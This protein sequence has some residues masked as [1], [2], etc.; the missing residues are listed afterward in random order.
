MNE[1]GENAGKLH[2]ET[3]AYAAL[4]GTDLVCGIGTLA[5]ELVRGAAENGAQAV[6]F[7]TKDEFFA[8]AG[9]LFKEGDNILVKASHGMNF[10]EIVEYLKGV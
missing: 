1:L 7:R 3:G 8:Q 10:P 9:R 2:Y 6:W 5:R 4:H